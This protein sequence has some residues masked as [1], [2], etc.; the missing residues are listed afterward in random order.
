MLLDQAGKAECCILSCGDLLMN[1]LLHYGKYNAMKISNLRFITN[2]E[3]LLS[4]ISGFMQ[5]VQ[6]CYSLLNNI[7]ENL[8][9][10]I[11]PGIY[12]RIVTCRKL[13]PRGCL[14]MFTLMNNSNSHRTTYMYYRIF[15]EASAFSANRA[16]EK[17][18]EYLTTAQSPS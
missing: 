11:L 8:L 12:N 6:N 9:L 1:S 18:Y 16:S 5:S 13:S 14:C 10:Q 4:S 2:T 15:R 17:T 7:N 3:Y